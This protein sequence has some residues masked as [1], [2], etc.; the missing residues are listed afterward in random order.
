VHARDDRVMED[1]ET[2]ALSLLEPAVAEYITR[3]AGDNDTRQANLEGWRRLR[4]RPHVLRD[5]TAVDT[6]T[7]VLG[8]PVAAPILL[9]PTALRDL[10]CTDGECAA[11]RAA[12]ASHTV[13]I[14]SMASS[15]P[16]AE[17]AAAAPD[18]PRFAQM[19][20]LR[21][22]GKTRAFVEAAR[23]AGA[24]AIVA[25]VDA[26]A[27]PY[28][29]GATEL[30]AH[31]A[32]L[33]ADYDVSVSIDDIT[34]LGEWSGLPIVVKGV[35]RGDDAERCVDAG[36]AAIYVSNHGGRIV[37]GCVDTASAL[38]DVVATVRGRAEVYVDGGIRTG[39]DVLRALALGASAVL[40]GR[41][42]LWGLAIGGETGAHQV[43]EQFR[44][45]LT[46]AL[47]FCGATSLTRI[48]RETVAS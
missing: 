31:V 6:S 34:Q 26:G 47:A 36:V 23:D 14:T 4:L 5:V 33:V 39:V 21:D 13:M 41:P 40:V 45:E 46:R 42:V 7:T 43:L 9:A 29:R 1:L 28:G 32:K 12:A 18:A 35:L 8:I 25:S 15:R 38:A 16:F 37:D 3:G 27:V 17:I 19:Y 10:V 2:R 48:E 44:T 30:G 20:V 11:A 24:R 22:R